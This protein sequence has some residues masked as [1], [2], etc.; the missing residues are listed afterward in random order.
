[1][2]NVT[3]RCF[4][5]DHPLAIAPFLGQLSG[6]L[7][8]TRSRSMRRETMWQRLQDQR[9]VHLSRGEP[10]SSRASCLPRGQC[11]KCLCTEVLRYQSQRGI[12]QPV[13]GKWHR[14]WRLRMAYWSRTGWRRS[15][16]TPCRASTMLWLSSPYSLWVLVSKNE[17]EFKDER[18]TI[19]HPGSC[20]VQ[21]SL[22]H[23]D[24]KFLPFDA[25]ARVVSEPLCEIG[26]S[27]K[28]HSCCWV[29]FKICS[30]SSSSPLR[31]CSRWKMCSKCSAGTWPITS[32]KGAAGSEWILVSGHYTIRRSDVS[33]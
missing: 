24:S 4:R 8:H 18:S 26:G 29:V 14:C 9:R 25:S 27:T 6:K 12:Q 19:V 28:V 21:L 23:A 10:S 11:S 2:K 33:Y 7:T 16:A 17:P 3:K 30:M 13:A 22:L 5:A 31:H 1:M 32:V 20:Y 15:C